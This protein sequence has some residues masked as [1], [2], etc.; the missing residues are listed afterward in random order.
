MRA[1]ATGA[2]PVPDGVL[3]QCLPTTVHDELRVL[4]HAT[5]L[6]RGSND[7]VQ[8]AASVG[9]FGGMAIPL[10]G[11]N[12]NMSLAK[13]RTNEQ[14]ASQTLSIRTRIDV[15]LARIARKVDAVAKEFSEMLAGVPLV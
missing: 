9:S 1:E 8:R 6:V 2:V 3:G 12:R 4:N 7:G 10:H 14:D 11:L 15:A 5:V 13:A